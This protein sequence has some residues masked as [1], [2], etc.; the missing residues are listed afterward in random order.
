[1][2]LEYIKID[3]MHTFLVNGVV[4]KMM[5]W[6]LFNMCIARKDLQRPNID[7]RVARAWAEVKAHY[8]PLAPP[9]K[10]LEVSRFRPG[11]SDGLSGI[12]FKAKAKETWDIWPGILSVVR[13][14]CSKD[15]EKQAAEQLDVLVSLLKLHALT[16]QQKKQWL[17]AEI[18][19]LSLCDLAGFPMT[20]KFHMM[21]H[22]LL[23]TQVD[24]A[25]RYSYCFAEETKNGQLAKLAKRASNLSS[26]PEKVV[27][28]HEMWAASGYPTIAKQ[29][30]KRQQQLMPDIS[31]KRKVVPTSQ[32][33]ILS[34]SDSTDLEVE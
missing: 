29:R 13:R 4:N 19:L 8:H 11:D 25:P 24:C 22:V 2:K 15:T 32:C 14:R 33:V 6:L 23:Q 17:M 27:L 21:Q 28:M 1:M 12:S 9:I 18:K 5:A 26:L 31:K 16:A 3:A 7:A 10:D 30:R 20:P 34:E